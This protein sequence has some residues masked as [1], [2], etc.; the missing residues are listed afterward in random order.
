MGVAEKI[1][2]FSWELSGVFSYADLSNIIGGSSDVAN[3]R[4]IK[5]LAASGIVTKIQRGVY[6]TKIFDPWSLAGRIDKNCYISMDSV[7][8]RAG[9]IGTV[10]ISVSAVRT[11]PRR[12]RVKTALGNITYYS[13]NKD[14]FFGFEK[15]G[16]G[17]F[18]ADPEKAYLDMLYY[19]TKGT[20]FVIDPLMEVNISRLN[21]NRMMNYLKRYKNPKFV[22]FVKGLIHEKR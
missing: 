3:S 14:L 11:A 19:Y 9:L 22:K 1:A 18:V 2:K 17:V 6:V 13:L 15:Q 4:A 10:P 21:K 12:R 16:N 8:A 20:R 5:R 7:L